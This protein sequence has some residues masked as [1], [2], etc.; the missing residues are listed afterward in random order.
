[1]LHIDKDYILKALP[2]GYVLW[3][4]MKYSEN[5]NAG[6]SA[7]K[8]HATAGAERNDAY[9][10]GHPGG[11]HKKYRSPQ[12]F[13][14]HLL[15]LA[16]DTEG[17]PANCSC[18]LCFPD[19]RNGTED[20]IMAEAPGVKT[21]DAKPAARPV[22]AISS[23]VASTPLA[24]AAKSALP[25][26]ITMPKPSAE[27]EFDSRSD[28]KGFIYRP[29]ELAWFNKGT[30]WG[31]A[32]ICR[33]QMQGQTPRYLLQPLSNPLQLQQ[34]QVRGHDMMRPWLAWSVPGTT[35]AKLN[36]MTFDQVPWERVVKGEFREP[37]R[38]GDAV[39]DGSILAA[40][41]ADSSYS[42]FERLNIPTPA[43]EQQY[44]GMFMGGEKVWINEPVRL[45]SP[46]GSGP[47]EYFVL[48]IDKLIERTTGTTSSLTI[49]GDVYKFI[50]MPASD[51]T[52][53]TTTKQNL[54][55]RMLADITWRNQIAETAKRNAFF[56]WRLVEPAARKTLKDI[57]GRWYES[58][59]LVETLS[60]S[61]K[62]Q[63]ELRVGITSDSSKH[64]NSFMEGQ[65]AMPA[66]KK[67]RL[68]ALGGSVP[69]TLKISKGLNGPIEDSDFLQAESAAK[70][71]QQ[72]QQQMHD[73]SQYIDLDELAQ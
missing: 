43:N 21:E 56:E 18:K 50:T 69:S 14:P 17:D 19:K 73:V 23:N 7:K 42:L 37:G 55:E 29:G 41:A 57:R 68:D 60:G 49:V 58:A 44:S 34:T 30:A 2:E 53:Q 32:V 20:E 47:D 40:K 25:R 27:Q 71:Q 46:P 4:Q 63:Q 38:P 52:G 59:C 54:P 11:R 24:A 70:P 66:R 67:N 8:S 31:L 45:V 26:T 33:R 36:S 72:Q 16:T 35:H 22:Q 5:P 28:F 10:F 15:W 13:F 51:R 12:E 1:M 48:I 39:V 64:M 6:S 62:V 9:L 65:L 3:Q 61:E